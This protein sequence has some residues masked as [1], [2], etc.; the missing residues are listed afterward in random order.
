[1]AAFA[2]GNGMFAKL[3]EDLKNIYRWSVVVDMQSELFTC[4]KPNNL[5]ETG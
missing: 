5:H 3:M 2:N 1:M 4:Y